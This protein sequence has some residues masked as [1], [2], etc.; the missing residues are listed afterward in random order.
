MCVGNLRYGHTGNRPARHTAGGLLSRQRVEGVLQHHEARHKMPVRVLIAGKEIVPE[1]LMHMCNPDNVAYEL[2]KILP[3]TP[4]R[5]E[6]LHGYARMRGRLGESTAA[7][8]AAAAIWENLN[9][10]Y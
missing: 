10:I 8:T 4:G 5:D 1:M 6:M 2:E 9:H 3:G 7:E